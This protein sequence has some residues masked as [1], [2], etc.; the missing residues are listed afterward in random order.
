MTPKGLISD[1][2][3]KTGESASVSEPQ[4]STRGF[5]GI[6]PGQK[7]Q[8]HFMDCDSSSDD[9]PPP[10]HPSPLLFLVIHHQL[11]LTVCTNQNCKK[12]H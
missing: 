2:N 8:K 12:I 9:L 5:T 3:K 7:L 6:T 11:P 4:L 10:L 1:E